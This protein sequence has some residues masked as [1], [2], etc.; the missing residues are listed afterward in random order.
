[1]ENPSIFTK[2]SDSVIVAAVAVTLHPPRLKNLVC[3]LLAAPLMGVAA[4]DA[5]LQKIADANPSAGGFDV[6]AA[7]RF[8][9]LALACVHKEYPN[10]IRHVLNSD[11]DVAP[12]RK[13][14]PAFCG[15]YDWHS[16]VHGHWLLVRLLRTFPDASFAKAA[17]DA[18]KESLTAENLK[19]E[20][21]YLRGDGRAS[22]ER[23]YGLAWLLQLCAELREWD[24]PQAQEMLANLKPLEDVAVERLRTWLPKLSHPVRIGEHDQTAF[25]LGLILDYAHGKNDEGVVKLAADS[26]RKFFSADKNCPLAY[27]P[28]GEDFLSPCLGEADVMR[29]VLTK[30]EFAKWLTE[31]LPQI[32]RTATANWLPVTVSPD[33]SDPKLAHLDGLNL[34]RAW[35]LE[36][37]ASVLPNEDSR[38]PALE[39]AAEAHR[40]AGLAAV[41]GAH[42]EGGHWLGSFAVYLTTKRGIQK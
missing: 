16:S 20:A 12:P 39:A 10:K 9:K 25:A 28:S 35:M 27:E 4:E 5:A 42:Y 38:R 11:A 32:P 31:F 15:C 19:A 14:T 34:S 37:I 17:R 23:P 6:S 33:P 41:T 40:R 22:F 3:A 7:E 36:G 30:A 13:L 18:L 26:A 29:R 21:A 24:D 2:R 1:M 8:A